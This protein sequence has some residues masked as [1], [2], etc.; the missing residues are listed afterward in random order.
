MPLLDW[1]NRN[2]AEETAENVPYHLLKFEKAYG[3]NRIAKDNLIIKGDN[4]Q[5]LK[6]LLPLY[7]NQIKC[8]FIDPPYNTEQAFEHYDDKLEHAQWLYMMYPRLQLLKDLLSEDGSIW[9]TVDDKEAHYLKVICDEVYGRDNFVAN[10][11]WEKSDSPK[12]DSNHFSSRHDHLLI[13]SKS[14]EKLS[15]KK[16]IGE[17]PK[18]YNRTDDRGRK[19]YTKPLRSMGSGEDTREA[20]P[21][22]FFALT[23]PD[24]TQVFPM[25]TK[26]IEGRWRWGLEKVENNIDLIEWVNGKNG[27]SAYYRIYADNIIGRP[28]ETIWT[29]KDTGSNR[30]SK[31]EIKDLFKSDSVFR[32]P[33]PE[34]LIMKVLELCTNKG[35]L[36]LD[37]FLGSGT[38]AAVAHKMERKYIGIEMG[39]H[40]NTLV[41]PRLKKVIEGEQGGISVTKDYYELKE[42]TL[43]DLDLAVDDIKIFNKVLQKIGKNSDLIDKDSLK[44]IKQA[45]KLK[46]NKSDVVWQGGGGFS[47][48]TLGS[49]VFDEQG[50]L[51][52][53]VKFNDLASYV[54]WLETK[55]PLQSNKHDTPFLGIHNEVAYY[56]LYNG[57]LG[58]E[59]PRGGNLLTHKVLKY[60]D[61]HY[62]YDGKRI[63]IGEA[64]RIG[65]SSLEALNIEFKQIPYALYGTQANKD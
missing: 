2:Q 9:I 37:S 19:Y 8:I 17:V 27:W 34:A 58:D 43:K 12:M 25:K 60:L 56:L 4:L 42:D 30:T 33:K 22:M 40:A 20:R 23:A 11:V 24:G 36:V 7:G 55:T 53:D 62:P 5:A 49:P 13:Y 39:E 26:E 16:T 46:K 54:W 63:I 29:H 47:F 57:V 48:Y 61:K 59:R 1:V 41:I 44:V 6:A 51:H 38:T 50:F 64:T 31:K 21:S 35:D 52:S 14:I 18:H 3:D 28:P 45:T 65:D 15:I 32:T 10:I